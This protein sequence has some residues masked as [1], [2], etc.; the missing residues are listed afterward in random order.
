MCLLKVQKSYFSVKYAVLLTWK[1]ISRTSMSYF[2]YYD[3]IFHIDTDND[4]Q[5]LD[6][7]NDFTLLFSDVKYFILITCDATCWCWIY[8]I[9]FKWQIYDILVYFFNQM[10]NCDMRFSAV[11][12]SD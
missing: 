4:D 12:Y 3:E 10:K 6:D 11:L 9:E 7:F 1:K 5:I 8:F 2:K